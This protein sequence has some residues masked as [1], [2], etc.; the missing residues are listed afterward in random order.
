MTAAPNESAQ[1]VAAS[2]PAGASLDAGPKER[3]SVRFIAY[4]HAQPAGSKRAFPFAKIDGKL[5]VRVTDANPKAKLW[6][7]IVGTAALAEVG[8]GFSLLDG[9][10]SV[11]MNF[12]LVRPAGH[13]GKRGLRPSA[14][15]RPTVKPDLLKLARAVEDALTGI[16]YADDAR[17]V[18]EHLH[19]FYV[20]QDASARVEV[21]VSEAL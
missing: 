9:P 6:Q 11:E 10:L 5:G 13:M 7:S 2:H 1:Q 8:G 16:L 18:D 19:K 15:T 3:R 14:P 20:D 4:G 12:Y 17:I 21:I